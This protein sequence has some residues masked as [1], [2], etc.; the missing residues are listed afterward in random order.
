M[1]K[2]AYFRPRV[3]KFESAV[4]PGPT[5]GAAA[6]DKSFRNLRPFYL[7]C[8]KQPFLVSAVRFK[9]EGE[10]AYRDWQTVSVEPGDDICVLNTV[11]HTWLLLGFVPAGVRFDAQLR[12]CDK[13]GRI[14]IA[15]CQSLIAVE[16]RSFELAHL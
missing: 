9:F 16:S 15:E 11:D 6:E 4:F 14:G 12:C 7:V 5:W 10:E 3:G 13:E 2:T 8:H 1:T